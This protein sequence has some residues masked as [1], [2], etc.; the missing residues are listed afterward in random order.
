VRQ[1]ASL[2]ERYH[3]RVVECRV[4]LEQASRHHRQGRMYEMRVDLIVPGDEIIAS[5]SPGEDH[6]HEDMNVA[7]EISPSIPCRQV[8]LDQFAAR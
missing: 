2:L 5:R 4:V 6:A 1:K 8:D 3:D 7:A